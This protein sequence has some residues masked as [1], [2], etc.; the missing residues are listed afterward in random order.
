MV[1]ITS[2][3]YADWLLARRPNL[4]RSPPKGATPRRVSKGTPA[5]SPEV[6]ERRRLETRLKREKQEKSD[7]KTAE[8]G[9]RRKQLYAAAEEEL[10]RCL[11]FREEMG[12]RVRPAMHDKPRLEE[13]VA[14]NRANNK[15]I[16]ELKQRLKQLERWR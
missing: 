13:L 4:R 2:K 14:E 5:P 6:S 10:E 12:E 16:T 9:V 1:K 3:E 8:D 15:K 11:L 7:R